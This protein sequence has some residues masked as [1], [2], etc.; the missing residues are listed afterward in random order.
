MQ[1]RNLKIF[2]CLNEANEILACTWNII[3]MRF[4]Q[5]QRLTCIF[6]KMLL[7]LFQHVANC[8]SRIL[9]PIYSDEWMRLNREFDAS[10]SLMKA[11]EVYSITLARN[12]MFT[13]TQ[14][15]DAVHDNIGKWL[16]RSSPLTTQ[17]VKLLLTLFPG[18]DFFDQC[19]VGLSWFALTSCMYQYVSRYANC[20]LEGPSKVL[21]Y[22]QL[23]D[24]KGKSSA[25]V[26]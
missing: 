24:L 18:C 3:C 5:A 12:M 26:V 1:C 2:W 11:L 21:G 10:I 13:F 4:R 22:G 20:A 23:S 7:F 6:L 15:V 25:T 8:V 16:N 19:F 17:C 14:P 9:D